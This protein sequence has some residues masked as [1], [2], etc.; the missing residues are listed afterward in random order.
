M[1]LGVSNNDKGLSQ[2]SINHA[3]N[4][5]FNGYL[6]KMREMTSTVLHH[7]TALLCKNHAKKK[8]KEREACQNILKFYGKKF[9]KMINHDTYVFPLR[10]VLMTFCLIYKISV[11]ISF[12]RRSF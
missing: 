10:K 1:N 9:Y 2:M 5:F 3:C 8:K 12:S 11:S 7:H 6:D 4:V